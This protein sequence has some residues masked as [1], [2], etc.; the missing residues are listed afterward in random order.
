M[1]E[2]TVCCIMLTRDRPAMA[3]RAVE[4]FRRQTYANKRLLIYNSNTPIEYGHV[5]LPGIALGDGVSEIPAGDRGLTIGELRNKAN[6]RADYDVLCH[7][8]DDEWSHPNRIA[9]Q[10]ALLQSSGA[11]CVGFNEALFWDTRQC[12]ITV[13]PT[14]RGPDGVGCMGTV[15]HTGCSYIYRCYDPGYAIGSSLM[16]WR[17]AWEHVKFDHISHGEDV[18]FTI[19]VKTKGVTAFDAGIPFRTNEPRMICA[20]HS[21]NSA[22]YNPERE[23]NSY[24]RSPQWDA[25]CQR[26]MKL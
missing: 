17:S 23:K 25:Y 20:I 22:P 13:D 9:E 21:G 19:K 16:Y 3:K 2:P 11:A 8:D 26:E 14:R 12:Q 7:W 15:K 6:E 18:R 4:S 5:P 24:T 1:T 10:V